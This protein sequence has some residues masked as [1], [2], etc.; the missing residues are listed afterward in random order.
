MFRCLFA[1][2]LAAQ[3]VPKPA[4]PLP[5]VPGRA[6]QAQP[7]PAP[8]RT[9]PL[10][11]DDGIEIAGRDAGAV[12]TPSRAG[13]WGGIQPMTGPVL[14]QRVADYNLEAVL[15]PVKHTLDGKA[16]LVWRNRSEK[17]VKHLWMHLYLNGF[18]GPGSTFFSEEK[19][20]AGGFRGET[21]PKEGEYGYIELR[22]VTQGGKPLRWSFQ[23][24]D[25]GP[26]TDH[27]VVRVDLAEPVPAGGAATVDMDFFDQLP[28]V[29]ARTGYFGTYH[30]VGQWYPKVGVLELPGERGASRPRWNCHEFH[31]RSEFYADFG[32]YR[33]AI[34]IPKSYSLGSTGTAI[35]PPVETPQGMRHDVEQ[36]DVHD[37]VFAA[38]DQFAEPLT[39]TYRGEGSPE[40]SVKVL[41][42]PEYRP[43]AEQAL[44]ATIDSLGYFST[45]LGPYPYRQITV[46]VPPFNAF[47]SGGMEYE[48]FFTVI[49]ERVY[50]PLARYVTIHEAGHSYF[51]GLLASN[52][53]EE[54]FLD[55]GL[56]ELW[57]ARMVE[58]ER[59]ELKAPGVLGRF[60]R[61]PPISFW[62]FERTGPGATRHPA[63]PIAGNSW[64]RWS[65]GSYGL[66]YARTV[67]VLHDLEQQL[68][69]GVFARGMKEYYR[70]WH[71]RHP[72]SGDL[73]Q[74]L[75]DT[76][77]AHAPLV[78]RWFA[79]QIYAAAPVDDR[80]EDVESIEVVPQ[81]GLFLDPS[82]KRVER[83]PTE[84]REEIRRAREAFR[85][86]HPNEKNRGPFPFRTMV[87]V[88]RYAAGEPQTLAVT[89][90]DGSV[91]R[92]DFP[93]GERWHRFVFE[94]AVRAASAQ[95]DPERR[96]LLDLNKL[97][98]GHTR[99][100]HPEARRRWT[101]EFKA[102]TELVYALLGAL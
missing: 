32:T 9:G 56:D 61:L 73:E 24:P 43:A 17:T 87:S 33:A 10:A 31:L 60:F 62:D 81:P 15:D 29:V 52:E 100:G 30:L 57:G 84:A 49:G 102:W 69:E 59:L 94:R 13:A 54:P 70:R 77:G 34:T 93:A 42:G 4:E 99:E 63:D 3:P 74:A 80:V 75:A 83:T 23:H 37:F 89:F 21:E 79:E 19:K 16:R 51:M 67:L 5:L 35:R 91:E 82:G 14:S 92:M 38:W 12:K 50:R 18:E 6:K 85:K 26:E 41:Y 88:R 101:L 53:F 78:H 7:A 47:E 28:R 46:V 25:G 1:A 96:V 68:P 98:D 27:S 40:V 90:E 97:D 86:E 95:L 71:H 66:I 11:D 20:V 55:E 22:R 76:A 2:L 44:S 45:T 48:T 72:A 64:D 58:G 65:G 8:V 36:D 39:G